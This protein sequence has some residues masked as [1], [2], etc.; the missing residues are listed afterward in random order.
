ME[1]PAL[2]RKMAR[3]QMLLS[4]FDILFVSQKA[5]KGSAIV[6]FLES[7]ASDDYESLDF[8]FPDEYLMCITVGEEDTSEDVSWKLY[9]DGASNTLGHG[10]GAVLIS[11]EGVM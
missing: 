9:F 6:Y 7:Q 10:I 4:E 8:N 2:T 1:A 11:Q 3:W 5:V